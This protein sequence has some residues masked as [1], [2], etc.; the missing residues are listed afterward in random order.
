MTLACVAGVARGI[1]ALVTCACMAG[2]ACSVAVLT[3][4]GIYQSACIHELTFHSL[5]PFRSRNVVNLHTF[6]LAII[7]SNRDMN[8]S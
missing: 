4:W 8:N 6:Q 2:V 5:Y 7:R 1:A 3:P